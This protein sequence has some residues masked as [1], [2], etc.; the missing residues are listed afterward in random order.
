MTPCPSAVTTV[1]IFSYNG[2]GSAVYLGEETKD[3]HRSIARA[4]MWAL[5]V[6]PRGADR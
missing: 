6:G 4:A 3:A 1:A 5:V 2:Y